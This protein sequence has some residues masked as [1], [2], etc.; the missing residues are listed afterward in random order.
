MSKRKVKAKK[1]EPLPLV[2]EE[3]SVTQ[4][5]ETVESVGGGVP[6]EAMPSTTLPLET[7]TV[8][9]DSTSVPIDPCKDVLKKLYDAAP[10]PLTVHWARKDV[11]EF[12]REYEAFYAR[13][14]EL[15]K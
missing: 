11:A 7:T 4:A 14:G 12:R 9:H 6:P 1:V 3:P 13:L 5:A 15:A 10:K 2:K 8:L